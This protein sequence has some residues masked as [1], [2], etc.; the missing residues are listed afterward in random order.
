M[1]VCIYMYVYVSMGVYILFAYTL[2]KRDQYKSLL[3]LYPNYTHLLLS[4]V[5]PFTPIE[6]I[7]THTFVYSGITMTTRSF[8]RIWTWWTSTF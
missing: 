1:G 6:I 2:L 7:I 3:A 8:S 5:F 4:I